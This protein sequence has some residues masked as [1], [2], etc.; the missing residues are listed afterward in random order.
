MSLFD[1]LVKS[2]VQDPSLKNVSVFLYLFDSL[3]MSGTQSFQSEIIE[4]LPGLTLSNNSVSLL[5]IDG[6]GRLKN[7]IQDP[8]VKLG[9]IKNVMEFAFCTIVDLNFHV[10]SLDWMQQDTFSCENQFGRRRTAHVPDNDVHIVVVSRD[11]TACLELL[12]QLIADDWKETSCWI[13]RFCDSGSD[14]CV[15]QLDCVCWHPL[16]EWIVKLYGVLCLLITCS[17]DSKLMLQITK[18]HTGCKPYI[19]KY[20]TKSEQNWIDAFQRRELITQK[21]FEDEFSCPFGRYSVLVTEILYLII[22]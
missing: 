9:I 1:D 21:S 4:V 12:C 18:L 19:E 17:F 11:F 10:L 16:H 2:L 22:I 15:G 6:V 7:E 20:S 3:L 14:L 8:A 13:Q 5:L